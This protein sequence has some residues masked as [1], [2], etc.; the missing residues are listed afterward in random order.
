MKLKAAF[1]FF[2]F[3]ATDYF[4]SLKLRPLG[5][6]EPRNQSIWQWDAQILSVKQTTLLRVTEL[7]GLEGTSNHLI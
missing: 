1:L 7:F 4:E 6:K 3:K 5:M 2:F